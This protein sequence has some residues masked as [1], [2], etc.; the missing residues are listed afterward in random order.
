MNPEEAMPQNEKDRLESLLRDDYR[1]FIYEGDE[2]RGFKVIS[3]ESL[4][5]RR[6]SETMRVITRST[7]T[8]EHFAWNY[9]SGLTEMQE[10]DYYPE[11]VTP[12]HP[13]TKIVTVTEWRAVK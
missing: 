12:V 6:W 2:Y 4:G 8:G 3:V 5:S 9:E 13:V 11:P 10:D 7:I 1:N